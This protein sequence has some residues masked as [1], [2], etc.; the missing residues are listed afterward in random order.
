MAEPSRHAWQKRAA[1]PSQVCHALCKRLG[2]RCPAGPKIRVIRLRIR[3]WT[4]DNSINGTAYSLLSQRRPRY[5][6]HRPAKALPSAIGTRDASGDGQPCAMTAIVRV[7]YGRCLA[8]RKEK[9]V[10]GARGLGTGNE[11]LIFPYSLQGIGYDPAS[12]DG[13]ADFERSRDDFGC[14]GAEIH[15]FGPAGPA[16]G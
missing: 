11:R 9:F 10:F 8:W 13:R 4:R 5:A 12:A 15:R 2:K 7:A 14:H 3:S 6:Q 16:I 1:S